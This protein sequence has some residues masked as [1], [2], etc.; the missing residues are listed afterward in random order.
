MV[1]VHPLAGV[2][3]KLYMFLILLA[4]SMQRFGKQIS[5]DV[6]R[7]LIQFVTN[8]CKSCLQDTC[9]R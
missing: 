8:P 7:I 3:V 5:A 4:H 6:S 9:A 1:L 2:D